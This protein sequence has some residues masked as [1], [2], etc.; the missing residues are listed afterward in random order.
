MN[1]EEARTEAET[2]P[3]ETEQ[4]PEAET[5]AGTEADEEF[6][7]ESLILRRELKL[8]VGEE[9][10]EIHAKKGW[11]GRLFDQSDDT[12]LIRYDNVASVSLQVCWRLYDLIWGAGLVA[13]M[14]AFPFLRRWICFLITAAGIAG[15]GSLRVRFQMK[16]GE[17]KTLFCNLDKRKEL[18]SAL[19]R[20]FG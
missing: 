17:R 20:K 6:T 19:G 8:R 9:A 11:L 13:L 14:L 3:P 16:D 18:V 5:P 4:Q 7:F 15:S 1:E 2:L 12:L 10:V